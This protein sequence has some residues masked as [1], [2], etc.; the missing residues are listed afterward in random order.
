MIFLS[1]VVF[2]SRTIF[3]L[4]LVLIFFF[5][6]LSRKLAI[7]LAGYVCIDLSEA[8]SFFIKISNFNKD[9][10]CAMNR[11]ESMFVSLFCRLVVPGW[12]CGCHCGAFDY[13][14]FDSLYIVLYYTILYYTVML[15]GWKYGVEYQCY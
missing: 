10:G 13:I 4:Y 8:N 3:L 1:F 6:Q 14:P 2:A 15:F 5:S 11:K 12:G 7:V 9:Q